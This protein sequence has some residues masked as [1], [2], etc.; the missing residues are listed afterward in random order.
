MRA[1]PKAGRCPRTCRY[2]HNNSLILLEYFVFVYFIISNN[3]NR[4]SEIV[5]TLQRIL[6]GEYLHDRYSLRNPM[7]L[8]ADIVWTACV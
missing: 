1:V 7:E 6:S 2:C 3:F 8:Q 5:D 4:L